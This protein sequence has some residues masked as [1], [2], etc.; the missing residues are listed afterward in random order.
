MNAGNTEMSKALGMD[1]RNLWFKG[2]QADMNTGEYNYKSYFLM[3]PEHILYD[4]CKE[5]E[6]SFLTGEDMEKKWLFPLYIH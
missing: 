6:T 2:G 5:K 1:S 4:E 3:L